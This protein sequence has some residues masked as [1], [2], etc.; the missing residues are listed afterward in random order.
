MIRYLHKQMIS[1]WLLVLVVLSAC[2]APGDRPPAVRVLPTPT[3][4][5]VPAKPV[6]TITAVPTSLP[7]ATL[8]VPDEQGW[9]KQQAFPIASIDLAHDDMR[10]LQP[11]KTVIGDARIVLL[12]EQSHGDGATFLAKTR[13][14]KFLHQELGFTVLAFESSFYDCAVAWQQIQEGAPVASAFDSAIFAIWSQSAQMRPLKNYLAEAA[15]LAQPLELAGIDSQFQSGNLPQGMLDRLEEFLRRHGSDWPE[16]PAWQLFREQTGMLLQ[17]LYQRGEVTADAATQQEYREIM[18]QVQATLQ[19]QLAHEDSAQAAFWHQVLANLAT[20]TTLIW[21]FDWQKRQ[22]SATYDR[23]LRD[24]QMAENLAW[25]ANKAGGNQ[26][27]IVWAASVHLLKQATEITLEGSP[28]AYQG[29]IPMGYH[30]AQQFGAQAYTIGFITAEGS[31]GRPGEEP[32]AV[33]QPAAGD[34]EAL[35]GQTAW[36]YAFLDLRQSKPAVPWLQKPQ[37]SSSL[38]GY[39]R[40]T[41]IWPDTLDGIFFVRR[42]T[43]STN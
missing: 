9:L 7:T 43:P 12:G 22:P 34:F 31:Y 10:D 39:S 14:V 18:V 19:D 28:N 5:R 6:A 36:D 41:A 3:A 35:F 24:R 27:I 1:L 11:L 38:L 17:G 32:I 15:S 16:R 23:S 37:T 4:S 30:V 26:K 20:N 8:A 13:I 21:S 25:L 2:A 40:A 29:W 33:P 42:M